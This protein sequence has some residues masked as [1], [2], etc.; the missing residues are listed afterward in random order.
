MN[1]FLLRNGDNVGGYLFFLSA[2]E[3]GIKNTL[4]SF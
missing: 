1:S 3:Y 4:K 2:V